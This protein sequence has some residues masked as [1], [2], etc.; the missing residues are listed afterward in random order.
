MKFRKLGRT[1]LAVSEISLGTVEIGM[2]YGMVRRPEESQ[3]ARLLHRA[4]DLGI[5]FIDTARS[6]GA[7]EAIIG[8]TL[9]SRRGEFFLSSK[10]APGPAEEMR[11]AVHDSLAALRTDVID[12]MMFHCAPA[13]IPGDDAIAV[14][15]DLKRA[16]SIRYTG[17]SVYG[18]HAAL[19]AIECGAF[20]CIQ[21]AYSPLDR[22][23]EASVFPAAAWHNMGVVARSVL[24][25]GVL[26]HRYNSLP[27]SLQPLRAAVEQLAASAGI[28]AAGLP[29]LAYRYVLASAPPDTALV[30]AA[31]PEAVE[32]AVRYASRGPLPA[33]I[34]DHIRAFPCRTETS[35]IPRSGS[36]DP[37]S[38]E[39]AE[40]V[41][42]SV[43]QESVIAPAGDE[44]G[45]R[46]R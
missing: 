33:D 38:A 12:I 28:Q 27:A 16:G 37:N 25:R 8:R 24:L 10:V 22:R 5:N 39:I 7:S 46:S 17:V 20:D 9:A 43:D 18:E 2:D 6:Y 30:G 35:S 26:T 29:E 31:T 32:A 1:G 14:L 21:V 4:L 3:A 23:P 42:H 44:P 45:P 34:I 13:E 11:Q 41:A 36:P 40:R 15:E 19:S